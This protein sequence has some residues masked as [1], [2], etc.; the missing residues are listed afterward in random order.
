[1]IIFLVPMTIVGGLGR[2]RSPS[3]LFFAVLPLLWVALRQDLLFA[4]SGVLLTTAVAAFAL[5]AALG[6]NDLLQMQM[7]L[8]TGALA[9]L[10]ARA[11]RRTNEDLVASLI[12]RRGSLRQ[13]GR[14]RACPRARG[15]R[16]AERRG[17]RA[18]WHRHRRGAPRQRRRARAVVRRRLGR[19]GRQGAAARIEKVAADC[20]EVARIGPRSFALAIV[21]GA[22]EW[23]RLDSITAAVLAALRRGIQVGSG[24]QS[25][26][27]TIGTAMGESRSSPLWLRTCR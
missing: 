8:L 26:T 17:A 6:G 2:E 15:A 14:A 3:L 9:A 13:I 5:R 20:D 21:G 18:R 1:M 4:A 24:T 16:R 11:V 23:A 7:V 25:V 27:A 19:S 12:E 22:T 10:Y